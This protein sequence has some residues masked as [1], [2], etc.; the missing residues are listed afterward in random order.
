MIHVM[1]LTLS[2][3]LSFPL[4]LANVSWSVLECVLGQK[5]SIH[6]SL[7]TW[8]IKMQILP[9]YGLVCASWQITNFE[10]GPNEIDLWILHETCAK[11]YFSCPWSNAKKTRSEG[12]VVWKW[13]WGKVGVMGMIL[14]LA[15]HFDQLSQF[16]NWALA[17]WIRSCTLKQ[18]WRGIQLGPLA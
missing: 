17:Q 2:I 12:V 7:I 13:Q 6:K 3:W 8:C 18:I 4:W 5:E 16:K 14:G 15:R 9:K 10:L 1:K 11:C